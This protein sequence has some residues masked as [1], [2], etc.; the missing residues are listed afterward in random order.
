MTDEIDGGYKMKFDCADCPRSW[1]DRGLAALC[2]SGDRREIQA[3][4]FRHWRP[5]S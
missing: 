2:C 4:L 5:D 1:P 3:A